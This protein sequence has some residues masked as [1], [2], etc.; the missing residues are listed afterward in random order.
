M[1]FKQNSANAESVENID[2]F[3]GE[4]SMLQRFISLADT[5]S[6][7]KKQ[8]YRFDILI[9]MFSAYIKMVAG[10]LAYET[11]HANFPLSLP[12]VSTVNRFLA[13]NGPQIVEGEMRT[14][15]LLRYLQSRN[16]PLEISLSEDATRITPKIS[17]DHKTNQLSGFTLPFDGNGMP[18][19]LSFPARNVNEI[20]KHF[21]N[22]SNSVSSNAYI[23]MAQPVVPNSPPFCCLIFSTDSKFTALHI[24]RRWQFQARILKEKEITINNIAT[25]GDSRALMAMKVFSRIGQ[26]DLSYLDCEYYSCGGW[27]ETTFIQDI[28]HI[29]TKSRNRALLCSRLFP[30]GNKIISSTHLK[31]LIQHVSKDKHLLTYSDI[32]P[33]DRQNFLSAE[34]ICSEKTI[35]CLSDYVPE[36]EGTVLYLKMMRSVLNS[37]SDTDIT[38]EERVYQ[39]WYGVFF[40]RAWRSWLLNSRKVKIAGQKKS[41]H[42][43]NLKDNF[44][45]SNCFTCIELNAHSLVK[46]V[47]GKELP[48]KENNFFFPNLFD[49]QVCESTF[50]QLRSFTSTYCTVVNF[51]M[52]EIIN[53]IRKIQLQNEIVTSCYGRIKFPRFEKKAANISASKHLL[54]STCANF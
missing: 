51:N 7:R 36:S 26:Q 21:T 48:S 49:S 27:V 19:P 11:L 13:D 31:Y 39:I 29:I 16:L 14:D 25:D 22:T 6:T 40:C 2:E 15:E 20:Q 24:L 46:Q 3:N 5:N 10:L 41:K 45:S 38:S 12:S 18:V 53:R 17:Y 1:N 52:L 28:I 9:K 42:F 54:L 30:I 43:Y 34:K 32:E 47:L 44:M 8:G 35:R 50:R 4:I 33:K 37:L 23:Q